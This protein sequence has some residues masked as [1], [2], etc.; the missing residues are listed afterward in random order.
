MQQVRTSYNSSP[1]LVHSMHLNLPMFYNHHN[2]DG[3]IT[4]ISFA[5]GIHEGDPLRG[6][7]FV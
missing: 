2:H 5:M 4:I 3:D 7:I 6:P 1:L